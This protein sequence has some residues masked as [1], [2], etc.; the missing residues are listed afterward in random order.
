MVVCKF[1]DNV[2]CLQNHYALRLRIYDY[3][4]NVDSYYRT[5]FIHW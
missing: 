2:Y 4:Y 5:K 1:L 3:I